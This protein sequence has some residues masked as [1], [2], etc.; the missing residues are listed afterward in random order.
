MKKM[1]CSYEK[2]RLCVSEPTHVNMDCFLLEKKLYI[3][4]SEGNS[5][6]HTDTQ[7]FPCISTR[8]HPDTHDRLDG[9]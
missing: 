6:A 9:F 1:R 2:T 4:F 7:I 5:S 8:T 3:F